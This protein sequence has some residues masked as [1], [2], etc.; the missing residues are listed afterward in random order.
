MS[1]LHDEVNDWV[2][3]GNSGI[4]LTGDWT[5]GLWARPTSGTNSQRV[6]QARQSTSA[7]HSVQIAWDLGGAGEVF[8]CSAFNDGTGLIK[9]GNASINQWHFVAGVGSNI[10]VSGVVD[11]IFIDG[12]AS[13]TAHTGGTATGS[14]TDEIRVGS[15]TDGG[16]DYGGLTAHVFFFNVKLSIGQLKQLMKYPGS[17]RNSSLILYAPLFGTS[18]VEPDYS[19]RGNHGT[20]SG[21][22]KGTTEPPINNVFIIPQP[23]LTGAF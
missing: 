11:F 10:G 1:R 5:I 21:T 13:T 2:S 16:A 12:E 4:D 17:I 7:A 6:M 9:D 15:R 14:N 19:G 3:F 18:S 8:S 22:T 23:Q 20:L